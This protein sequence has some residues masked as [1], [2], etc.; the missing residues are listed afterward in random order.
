MKAVSLLW[1]SFCWFL[2]G[3][4]STAQQSGTIAPAT[5]VPPEHPVTE[6][7]LRRYFA[8]CHFSLRNREA[9]EVQFEGQERDLPAWYPKDV[10]NVTVKSVEDIDVVDI[11][12]PVYQKYFSEEDAQKI[13]RLFVT[14]QG[15]AMIKKVFD[16][17][18]QHESEGD[19]AMEARRKALAAQRDQEGAEVHAM[20][21]SM[22]PNEHR[23]V[24][25]FARSA[26]WQRLNS[27]SGQIV[28]EFAAAYSLKQKQVIQDIAERHKAEL[29]DALREYKASHPEDH[30]AP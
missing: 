28:Q 29:S 26:E 12:L 18:I 2:F 8:S 4:S 5:I 13:I 25:A 19:S 21:N 7:T 22:T 20:L 15:Q 10:W 14:P 9:L 17:S 24:E 11:A 16:D 6:A 1:L 3:I 23:E 27:L 30:T